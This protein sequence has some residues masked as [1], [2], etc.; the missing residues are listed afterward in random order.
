MEYLR[1]AIWQQGP[2]HHQH[3]RV[4]QQAQDVIG[5]FCPVGIEAVDL[6]ASLPYLVHEEADALHQIAEA[7]DDDHYLEEVWQ[8]SSHRLQ[9]AD[10]GIPEIAKDAVKPIERMLELS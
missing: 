6:Q 8:E 1:I 10:K 9:D 3:E 2:Y 5:R 4:A 7:N